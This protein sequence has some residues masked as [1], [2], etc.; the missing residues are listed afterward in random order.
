MSLVT[1]VLDEG[2][3]TQSIGNP[4]KYTVTT[5]DLVA[6]GAFTTVDINLDN[7]PAGAVVLAARV[8]H[9]E[10]V[11]GASISAST[12]RIYFNANALGAGTLDIFAAPGSTPAT[13]YITDVTGNG[14]GK[15]DDVNVLM[16]RVTTTGANLSVITAGNVE[17]WVDYTILGG[18]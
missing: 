4:R 15:F 10:A 9:S 3:V 5:A 13:H 14:A 18:S 7:L 2:R 1:T 17:V 12:A 8:K 6:G 11:V 16:L